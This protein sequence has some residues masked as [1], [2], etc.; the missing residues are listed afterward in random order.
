[1]AK[2]S[3]SKAPI[4]GY[5]VGEDGNP[6]GVAVLPESRVSILFDTS[7][8]AAG[9]P[10]IEAEKS[11]TSTNTLNKF[12]AWGDDNKYP[13][14]VREKLEKSTVALPAMYKHVS[15]MYG[16]GI[17]Y[18]F[19]ERSEDG[20]VKSFRKDDAVEAFI[21]NNDLT[22][23]L[24]AQAYT[25]RHFAQ[26]FTHLVA[27]KKGD[28]ISRITNLDAEL[29]R[30]G[31]KPKNG[32]IDKVGYG[33]WRSES[34]KEEQAKEIRLFQPSMGEKFTK[35]IK[36]KSTKEFAMWTRFPSVGRI[37][38]THAPWAGLYRKDGWLDVANEIPEII[39]AI[40]KNQ[41]ALKYHV[42]IPL[43]YWPVKYKDWNSMSQAKKEKAVDDLV[44]EINDTLTGTKNVARTL[45]TFHGVDTVSGK[46]LP[47]WEIEPIKDE[48][49]K[50][51]YIP[52]SDKADQQVLHALGIDPSIIGLQ[53]AG[54]KLGA[55]S[56]SDKRTG[57]LNQTSIMQMEM[58]LLLR[59]LYFIRDY[60]GWDENLRF[61]VKRIIPTTLNENRDGESE[62]PAEG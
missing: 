23:W 1:M 47:T 4:K 53:P 44:A 39:S 15:M 43:D 27:N 36:D 13:T 56:G 37:Y 59:P 9:A 25:Y 51:A 6:A 46:A 28:E 31:I 57:F 20:V 50:D 62:L 52:N 38:Y 40:H 8:D 21:C 33:D 19:A 55:G 26:C 54:G 14:Q 7:E 45:V 34:F 3:Q 18:F 2:E 29:T 60:N 61:G 49:S 24:M 12:W 11:L 30:L 22:E 42:K 35:K 48:L 10:P 17:D 58:D 32:P 41:I 16:G 5:T